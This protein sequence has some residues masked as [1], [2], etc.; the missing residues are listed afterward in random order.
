MQTAYE[1]AQ[2]LHDEVT[3][4]NHA[5]EQQVVP[6]EVPEI[7][8]AAP[9]SAA[10]GPSTTKDG[11]QTPTSGNG[12]NGSAMEGIDTAITSSN[13]T[14]QI[15]P[16]ARPARDLVISLFPMFYIAATL[17]DHSADVVFTDNID[18]KS[19]FNNDADAVKQ[20]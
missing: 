17:R 5:G 16:R 18:K 8:A 12:T 4:D 2:R 15:R 9:T 3:A 13:G 14:D 6:D 1:K 19:Q 10:S 20:V 11:I 7:L